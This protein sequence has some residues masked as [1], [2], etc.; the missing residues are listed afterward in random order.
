[1][2]AIKT[3]DLLGIAFQYLVEEAKGN[4]G[5]EK[6]LP[7]VEQLKEQMTKPPEHKPEAGSI[8]VEGEDVSDG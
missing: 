4:D 7:F 5:L 1:M 6:V 8:D 3:K 2:P